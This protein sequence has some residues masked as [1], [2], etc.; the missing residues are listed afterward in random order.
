MNTRK[1][2]T[3]STSKNSIGKNSLGK[4]S[5]GKRGLGQK[6]LSKSSLSKSSLGK[7]GLGKNSL[8]KSSLGK[9]G[10]K[11][12]A[13]S[14]RK[15]A[16]QAS[17]HLKKKKMPKQNNIQIE[18]NSKNPKEVTDFLNRNNISI[19]K[20]FQNIFDPITICRHDSGNVKVIP[21]ETKITVDATTVPSTD[22]VRDGVALTGFIDVEK[23]I[24]IK[25]DCHGDD[26]KTLFLEKKLP[27]QV[28][29]L[30]LENNNCMIDE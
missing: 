16:L 30:E 20:E 2:D 1:V 14:K 15:G 4:R 13:P 8:S 19:N 3:T 27:F 28:L 12:N 26:D 25:D 22:S 23:L 9:S 18:W 21:V 17:S 11:K 7:R 6:S 10:L 5:I 24:E 29:I